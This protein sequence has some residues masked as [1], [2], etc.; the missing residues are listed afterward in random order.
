MALVDL[1][2]DLS[3][4]RSEVS[5]EPKNTPEASKAT[6]NKNFAT[7]Q[8]ISAK[9]SQF[10]K[11]I[12]KQEPKQLES[13]LGST[14]LDDIRKF[15]QQNLLINSVSRF[16]KIDE[17]Y[18]S[19][20]MNVPTEMVSA[21]YGT[22]RVSEFTS[23][24]TTSDILPIRQQ[25]GI[26][27]NVSPTEVSKNQL[28]QTNNIV[29]PNIEITR[30]TQTFDRESTSPDVTPLPNEQSNNI[31]NPDID[32]LS[33]PLTFDRTGQSVTISKDL[34]SQTGN[35]TDPKTILDI[36]TLT[37]ERAE[38]SPFILTDTKQ[39]GFVQNPNIRVFRFD[40]TT[41]QTEDNSRLNLDGLPLRFVP[42]SRLDGFELPREI[43][44]QRYAG[45]SQQLE[46][47]SRLNLDTV[48]KTI[49]FGRHEDPNGSNF[50]II[51]TQ[52][53]NFFT[54]TN[55]KGFVV[56]QQKGQSLYVN[57]SELGWNGT[58]DSVPTT[59]FFTDV[60]G[61][62]FTKFAPQGQTNYDTESSVFGFVTV[63]AT[64]FF[65]VTKTHT[66]DGFK[67]F[68]T[69]YASD[70]K[71][72]SSV[73]TFSG[74][75][76]NAPSVNYFDINGTVSSDGF[77]KF[78]QLLDSKYIPDSSVFTWAGNRDE[79]PES[80]FFDITGTSTTVGFHRFAQLYDT[81]YIADSSQFD[82]D[83]NRDN[84]PEVNYFD[85]VGTS[86]SVGFHKFAQLY[87]TKYIADSSQFDWDGNRDN[88]PEV[89]YFD[90]NGS[91]TTSGFHKFA[92][93][94]D[95]KYIS[96]ASQFDWD[97]TRSNA[98]EVNYFDLNGKNT[99]AGFHRFAQIYDSKYIHES[100]QFDWDGNK[101]DAPSVNY[102]DLTSANTNAGFHTFAQKYDSKYIHESS[103]YDWDG[104]RSDSPEVNFFDLNKQHQTIGFHRLAQKYDSKYIKDASLFDFDGTSR[105]APEV[106]FFDLDKR[107]VSKGFEKFTQQYIT[108]Y[109]KDSSRFDFDGGKQ[110]APETDFFDISKKYTSKGFEKFPQLLVTR[111][112]KDSSRFDFD[113]ASSNAPTVNY[114]PNTNASGFTSFAPK[115]ET[116][117]VPDSSEFTF[118]G[119]L[120]TPINFFPDGNQS[121]FINKTPLLETKYVKDSSRFTFEG[122]L[123][124]PVDFIENTNAEGFHLKA[125]P[126]ETKYISDISR[127]TFKGTRQDVP[128][129][130]YFP[131]DFNDGFIKL[132]QPLET[133]FKQDISRFTFKGTR[134]DAPSVDYL[135][136]IPA[137]GFKTLVPPLETLFEKEASRFTWNGTRQDAPQ[138]DFFK[139]PASNPNSIV[140]FN[141]LFTDVTDTKLSDEFSRFSFAGVKNYSSVKNVPYTKFFGFNPNERSGFLVNMTNRNS[142]L[143]PLL[144]PSLSVDAPAD[145]RFG[146]EGDRS[147]IRRQRTT[148]NVGKYAPTTLGGL[149][150]SDGTNTGTAT[151]G[152]Q[153]P[154]MKV[155]SEGFSST[156]FR[157]Y[158]KNAKDSTQGLGYLTKWATTRR[159]PSPLDIQYNKYKLQDESVN[160][161]I[162]VFNQPYVVRGIQREGEVENQR[163]GFGVTFDDGI[164]RG[165]AVTQ[166]ERIA[167]DLVRLGKFTLSIKGGLFNLKQVGLQLM[168]P[169]VDVDPNTSTSGFLGQSATRIF[170]PAALLAN[171]AT[172][173][174]GFHIAR[175]GVLST[176]SDYLN[177]YEKAT[178]NRELNERFS[179]PD[180][181][182]FDALKPSL[183][184]G[185]QTDYNRLIGLMRELLPGS[186][187]PNTSKENT[188]QEQVDPT[189]PADLNKTVGAASNAVKSLTGQS[190]INR[191]SSLFG[192]PQ[193]FL[194]I[195]G[196]T[197]RRASHPYLTL[198]TT[199]PNLSVSNTST[200][201][202]D[203][204]DSNIAA[205]SLG[206]GGVAGSFIANAIN[207]TEPQYLQSAKRDIF[208]AE[209]FRY[210]NTIMGTNF[211]A[212]LQTLVEYLTE[213]NKPK[214]LSIDQPSLETVSSLKTF[215]PRYDLLQ[216]RV[217]RTTEFNAIQG[218][219]T[220]LSSGP[221]NI[222]RNDLTEANAIKRYRTANYDQLK[223]ND[224]NRSSKFND[225]R[226]GV[227]LDDSTI[228][229]I[230]DPN[231]ARFDTRNLTD[232]YGF[233]EQGEPGAQRNQPYI[234][235]IQYKRF[236]KEG[237]FDNKDNQT[238]FSDYGVATEKTIDG[239]KTKFRGDRINI[240]DY[241]RANFNINTNLVYEKGEY[242]DGLPGKDDLVEFYFSSLVLSGHKNCPAEVIVFRATF[243]SITDNHNPSWNAVKY[244]GRADPL[245]TYQGY[246]REISFGFTVHIGSRDEMKASWRKLNYL[247]SWTAPEYLKSGLMRGPMIRLNIGHLYRKMPGYISSLSYTF[248]NSQTTWETAKLPE[249]MNL[250]DSTIRERTNP[251]VLQLPKH[252]QV[253][254]SFV[255]VGVYR[256]EFRGVMY[257]LYDDAAEEKNGI[258][259]G[260]MPLSANRVNYFKEFDDLSGE[261]VI[262]S[263]VDVNK[264][265]NLAQ[266]DYGNAGNAIQKVDSEPVDG[267]VTMNETITELNNLRA[268]ERASENA[269]IIR[270]EIG[271]A[272]N[273]ESPF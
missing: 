71:Q 30:S 52:Q 153:V 122:T 57:N 233:G 96:E 107:F 111:Y 74:P 155:K 126:L 38:Q 20:T 157:K 142:S 156:Y 35:V 160:R 86:T 120:P 77:T 251:G 84:A 90:V 189:K 10:G 181:N 184:P 25:Q 151:L 166:A 207:Q 258:E 147:K 161:E 70:Y 11:D 13:K 137:L 44:A 73:F 261:P 33:G 72:D 51:G 168:N 102:F 42:I 172:A 188:P 3:K 144:D 215:D 245:Y 21:T 254:V 92:Q 226:A 146:I 178:T 62:G 230:T 49:P 224:R 119:S 234:N 213:S 95:T 81:K 167:M 227:S 116:E 46:D 273:F 242:T 15:V 217:E 159:S 127:F 123:P 60:N 130:D 249:D 145:I 194:G 191:L 210:K 221:A 253:S 104:T 197:I 124:Q 29:N 39:D 235:T 114:F 118:K 99:N 58:R 97:G 19:Q 68:S 203:E 53:V 243:D 140:G 259:T 24:L 263:G 2:S 50:S 173:R 174:A 106:D 18:S 150:W 148:D 43:D 205:S 64:N 41:V 193:S 65:D 105:D 27:N 214:P 196:T 100:S 268:A 12:K 128:S 76:Q 93:L 238:Q 36:N 149:F 32:I 271:D 165:G 61:S 138:V 152:N 231:I 23:R 59:N 225:F 169:S 199:A 257:S 16:S 67:T 262:Y 208:Y 26:Y 180:K 135:Q 75:S 87:D 229:F 22:V 162:A 139:I 66:S 269:E 239:K 237:I 176:D 108:R 228:S 183:V 218:K 131:N 82:W 79:S 222:D 186:F 45:E 37:Y 1:S 78:V 252:I 201:T 121:G 125:A 129:V 206:L 164:V 202:K 34:I 175:H 132:A 110:N 69:L 31:V 14:K 40:G 117:Y 256:P 158:E 143:Y 5:R 6:N 177:K 250:S 185:D 246:E 91:S 236:A 85:I 154:F 187:K 101:Q 103:I 212:L 209:S 134:Q 248:D 266:R 216:T 133:A 17:D 8:P 7:V 195:G 109:I 272:G 240:I 270:S 219:G 63:K 88:A 179:S 170:N 94:Y 265:G 48:I 198:Y 47:N 54:D 56:K 4:F 244:M 204:R 247:A 136:N 55:A 182:R 220:Q 241:K 260:L 28:E 113:G 190:T 80:N 171:V 98:P 192:G 211:K 89:N 232:R 83:G 141:T 255:P 223:R 9:L 115:L 200:T 267:S 163:W 264:E 112:I